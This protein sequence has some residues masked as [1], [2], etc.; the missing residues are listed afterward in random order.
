M[1]DLHLHAQNHDPGCIPDPK[2][3]IEQAIQDNLCTIGFSDHFPFPS[4]FKD[5]NKDNSNALSA[6]Q[7]DCYYESLVNLK[8]N[9]RNKIEVLIGA[10]IDWIENHKKWLQKTIQKYDFDFIRGSIHFFE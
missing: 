4:F 8:N 2:I 3:M 9:Y 10:E 7:W 6:K 5:P 1:I